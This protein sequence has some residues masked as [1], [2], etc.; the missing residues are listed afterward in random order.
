MSQRN[1]YIGQEKSICFGYKGITIFRPE[2]QDTKMV[3]FANTK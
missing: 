1:I 2:L 3:G